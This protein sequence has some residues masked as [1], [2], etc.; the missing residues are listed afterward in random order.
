MP[1]AIVNG[2]IRARLGTVVRPGRS[3]PKRARIF[4]EYSS[5]AEVG[6]VERLCRRRR[7]LRAN[8][9]AQAG[10]AMVSINQLGINRPANERAPALARS[11]PPDKTRDA[12]GT[13]VLRPNCALLIDLTVYPHR[14]LVAQYQAAIGTDGS[15]QSRLPR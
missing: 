5:H 9:I 14:S 11:L 2:P 1:L 10:G 7:S 4:L 12:A 6:T 15:L 8:G 13:A 3:R